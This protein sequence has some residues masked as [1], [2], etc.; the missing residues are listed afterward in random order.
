[1]YGEIIHSSLVSLYNS[2]TQVLLYGR[3]RGHEVN[4]ESGGVAPSWTHFDGA[5]SENNF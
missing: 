3:T 4:W 2:Y 1:M 5:D